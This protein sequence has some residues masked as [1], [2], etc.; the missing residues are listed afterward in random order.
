MSTA[1]GG[2]DDNGFGDEFAYVLVALIVLIII[3]ILKSKG[4][5]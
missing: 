3:A 1:F 5:G 4:Q 2:G